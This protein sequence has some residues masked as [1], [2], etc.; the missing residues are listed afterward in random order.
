MQQAFLAFLVDAKHN[1]YAAQGDEASAAR[2]LNGSRQLE[3][4]MGE[5]FY[6]DI[7]FG[8]SCFVGQETVYRDGQPYWSMS[9]A[10]GVE[11]SARDK[12][13]VRSIYTHL[14]AALRQVSSAHP[15]RGPQT[16]ALG[17]Y[18]YENASKGG[19]DAFSRQERILRSGAVVYSLHYSGG[20]LR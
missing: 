4:R 6:R 20:M 8:V 2:L 5:L 1:T 3:Y 16:Y 15:F 11:P 14:R 7:Y 19:L 10:G 13:Q 18:R 12:E 17:P 9:Y